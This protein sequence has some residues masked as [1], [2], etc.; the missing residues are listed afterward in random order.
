[1]KKRNV[2][3]WAAV[4]EAVRG[5]RLRTDKTRS[6]MRRGMIAVA[7][8]STWC[9]GKNAPDTGQNK[10]Q[11]FDMRHTGVNVSSEIMRPVQRMRA[12][13]QRRVCTRRTK[14]DRLGFNWGGVSDV[15]TWLI[16][17]QIARQLCAKHN[18]VIALTRLHF[19]NFECG[20]DCQAADELCSTFNKLREASNSR[21]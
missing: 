12:W 19:H 8:Q 5:G 16:K 18:K 11:C 7:G 2:T 1:V 14:P 9:R 4:S 15:C 21:A 10:S 13:K 3:R 6:A 17:N 20:F